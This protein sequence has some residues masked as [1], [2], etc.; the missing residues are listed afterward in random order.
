MLRLLV[1][2]QVTRH[3]LV[4]MSIVGAAMRTPLGR[5]LPHGTVIVPFQAFFFSHPQLTWVITRRRELR[6]DKE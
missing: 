6:R 1:T 4:E 2:E 5:P 3:R